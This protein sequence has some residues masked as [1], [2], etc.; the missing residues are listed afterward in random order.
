M[1]K[2]PFVGDS[3]DYLVQYSFDMEDFVTIDEDDPFWFIV[4]DND[5][6]ITVLSRRPFGEAPCFLR[7]RFRE[8]F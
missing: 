5:E 1:P 6:E 4:T 2:R 7:V 8:N 3:L